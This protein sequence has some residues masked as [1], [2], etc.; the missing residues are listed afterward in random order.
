VKRALVYIAGPYTRPDRVANTRTA[1]D[2]AEQVEAL[3]CDVFIPHLSLLWHLVAPA[4]TER[5]YE[6]DYAI[7][8]R[9]DGLVRFKGASAGADAELRRA[10]DVLDIPVFF[11]PKQADALARFARERS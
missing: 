4:P 3:G 8:D 10:I 2:V 9:C 7:L 5:W 11:W 1:I 6:R